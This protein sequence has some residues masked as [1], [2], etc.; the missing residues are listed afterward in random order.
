[1]LV[2][3]G[4]ALRRDQPVRERAPMADQLPRDPWHAVLTASDI[5]QLVGL[6]LHYP[7]R[8]A[9]GWRTGLPAHDFQVQPLDDLPADIAAEVE[10]LEHELDGRRLVLVA[11]SGPAYPFYEHDLR[12]LTEW[13]DRTG[14]VLGL[15][16]EP[17]D[18]DAPWARRLESVA[19]DLSHHRYPSTPAVLRSAGMVVTD[20]S[21]LALDA[22]VTGRPVA[23]LVHVDAPLL[24]DLEHVFPG[25]VCRSVEELVE[26]ADDYG[27]ELDEL[28]RRLLAPTPDGG[29]AARVVERIRLEQQAVGA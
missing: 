1:V 27:S 14:S 9:Q 15:R 6:G 19:L 20:C 8:Y 3:D 13:G 29:A 17:R 23:A 26:R 5:D 16:E 11:P 18:L 24:L 7:V 21:G 25:P 22:A 12:H 4:L 28:R 2:R 10:R